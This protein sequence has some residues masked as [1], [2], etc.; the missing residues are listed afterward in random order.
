MICSI[1]MTTNIINDKVY[2]AK[3][4]V[5]NFINKNAINE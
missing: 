1:Y 2:E 5:T 3:D 4:T